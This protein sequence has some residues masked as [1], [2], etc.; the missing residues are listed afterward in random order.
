MAINGDEFI[1]CQL[2]SK[3][4]NDPSKMENL[5]IMDVRT[6]NKHSD[7]KI[8]H[9]IHLF[10]QDKIT[11]KRLETKKLTVESLLNSESKNKLLKQFEAKNSKNILTIVLYDEISQSEI[12]PGEA[13][14]V[15]FNNIVATVVNVDCKILKGT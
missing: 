9:S 10:C 12:K 4:I 6:L 3:L 8:K 11:K 13:I 14:K 2:L 7:N 15:A 1:D 5:L